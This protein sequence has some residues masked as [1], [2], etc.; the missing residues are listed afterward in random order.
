M[1]KYAPNFMADSATMLSGKGSTNSG[2]HWMRL[3]RKRCLPYALVGYG[4]ASPRYYAIVNRYYEPLRKYPWAQGE[5][6]YQEVVRLTTE[7]PGY[8]Y[9]AKEVPYGEE[10]YVRDAALLWARNFGLSYPAPPSKGVLTGWHLLAMVEDVV[11]TE[12]P[13]ANLPVGGYGH[14]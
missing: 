13:Y 10:K 12:A 2:G 8:F 5:R 1:M 9:A 14:G 7:R 3:W 11:E 6:L 4:G